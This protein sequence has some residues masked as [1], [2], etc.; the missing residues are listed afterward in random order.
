MKVIGFTLGYEGRTLM[1]GTVSSSHKRE[2]ERD[3]SPCVC[4]KERPCG[5][6]PGTKSGSTLILGLCSFQNSKKYMSGRGWCS[7]VD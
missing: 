1:M 3:I 5:P 7:S 2:R 4:T 6:S